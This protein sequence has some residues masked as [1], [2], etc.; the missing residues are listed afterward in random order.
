M[1]QH[2]PCQEAELT[3]RIIRAHDGLTTL[4]TSNTNTNVCFLNHSNIVGTVTDTK[5]HDVQPMLD[6]LHHRS[7]LRWANTTA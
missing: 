7:L 3:N 6:H 1:H 2:E 5:R 4:F